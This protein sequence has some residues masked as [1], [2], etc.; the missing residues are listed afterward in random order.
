MFASLI[1]SVS[2]S[3]SLAATPAML[4]TEETG[5]GDM[6]GAGMASVTMGAPLPLEGK[7]SEPHGCGNVLANGDTTGN[8][9]GGSTDPIKPTAAPRKGG[10]VAPADAEG[11][12]SGGSG[13][14]GDPITINAMQRAW[15]LLLNLVSDSER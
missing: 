5:G 12:T 2:L 13:G 14:S 6:R 4:P 8:G 3:A 15:S 9:T 1:A 7:A 11:G 10:E